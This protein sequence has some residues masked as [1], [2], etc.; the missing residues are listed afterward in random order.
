[1]GNLNNQNKTPKESYFTSNGPTIKDNGPY[2]TNVP[3]NNITMENVKRFKDPYGEDAYIYESNGKCY[4]KDSSGLYSY[5][6]NPNLN[7]YEQMDLM[8]DL[9]GY[10]PNPVA[11]TIE[12]SLTEG[13]NA[14]KYGLGKGTTITIAEEVTG[15]IVRIPGLKE[16]SQNIAGKWAADIYDKQNPKQ[17]LLESKGYQ[18]VQNLYNKLSNIRNSVNNVYGDRFKDLIDNAKQSGNVTGVSNSATAIRAWINP[19]PSP[20]TF[21]NPEYENLLAQGYDASSVVDSLLNNNSASLSDADNMM[22][23]AA[24]DYFASLS[25]GGSG[26]WGWLVGAIIGIILSAISCGLG[27]SAVIYDLEVSAVII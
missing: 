2:I 1:M 3:P 27:T 8:L 17:T 19:N 9:L 21:I 26:W 23:N 10:V 6:I 12:I 15:K 18:D 4:I 7:P 25:G 5:D 16:T 13:K 22:T 14:Y 24:N 11:E 20:I